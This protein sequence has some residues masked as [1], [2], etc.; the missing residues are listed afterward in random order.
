MSAKIVESN[1]YKL[2]INKILEKKRVDVNNEERQKRQKVVM[3]G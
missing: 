2:Y 1:V 3:V